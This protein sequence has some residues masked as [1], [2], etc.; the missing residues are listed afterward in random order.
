[1]GHTGE[2]PFAENG[3]HD[4]V[5]VGKSKPLRHLGRGTQELHSLV[6]PCEP[7][8]EPS[9]IS[10]LDNILRCSATA[11]E[12]KPA[13]SFFERIR[14]L[15]GV[16]HFVSGRTCLWGVSGFPFLLTGPGLGLPGLC[17]FADWVSFISC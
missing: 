17:L 2:L 3:Y 6:F 14:I 11:S 8:E 16:P 12:A 9:N 1:M 10:Y 5:E 4:C 7:S 13:A 15:F